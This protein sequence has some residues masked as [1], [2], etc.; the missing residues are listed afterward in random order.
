MEE[1]KANAEPGI[2]G[3]RRGNGISAGPEV[4]VGVRS[5][6]DAFSRVRAD[7]DTNG[8]TLGGTGS[9]VGAVVKVFRPA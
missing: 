8:A 6:I 5:V 2:V 1:I 9:V 3:S 7:G 4:V